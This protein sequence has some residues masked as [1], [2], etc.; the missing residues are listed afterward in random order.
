MKYQ[1]ASKHDQAHQDNPNTG[2]ESHA[3]SKPHA[4]TS[5]GV[6]LFMA[7][8]SSNTL[9]GRDHVQTKLTIGSPDDEYEQEADRV[10]DEVM[11]KP[12]S[13][14]QRQTEEGTKCKS[15]QAQ[16]EVKRKTIWRSI[17]PIVQRQRIQKQSWPSFDLSSGQE[18]E[19]VVTQRACINKSIQLSADIQRQSESSFEEVT[20][21]EDEYVR[22]KANVGTAE[23]ASSSVEKSL[24]KSRGQGIPLANHTLSFMEDRFGANFGNVRIHNDGNAVNL[25]RHLKSHAF[26]HGSDIYFNSGKYNPESLQGQ[27]LLAHELT[28]VVQQSPTH[29]LQKQNENVIQCQ[30]DLDKAPSGLSCTLKTGTGHTPGT[31]IMFAEGKSSIS[32][33]DKAQLATFATTWIANGSSATVFVDG[34]AS[35]DGAQS[36]NWRLSCKRAEAVKT[37]LANNGVSSSKIILLAH[38]ESTEFSTSVL[39]DNRRVVVSSLSIPTPPAIPPAVPPQPAPLPLKS[40]KFTSDHG[41]LKDNNTNWLYSGSVVEPEWVSDPLRNKSISQTKNTRLVADVTVN[42]APAGTSFDLIGTGINSNDTSFSQSGNISTGTDQVISVTAD[43]NLPNAVS[44]LDRYIIWKIKVGGREQLAG[45][46]GPHKIYITYATPI[47]DVTEKRMA[48]SC[49]KANTQDAPEKIADKIQLGVSSDTSFGGMIDGWN[50]LAGGAGDCDNQAR[51]MSYAVNL[52]GVSPATVRYVRASTNAGAGNC[53]DL[54][55]R[56]IWAWGTIYLIMDFNVGS[57]HYWNAYEGICDTAGKYYAITPRIKATDDYDMLTKISCLQ[58]WVKSPVP[59]GHSGWGV[60]AAFSSVPK[61]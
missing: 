18:E 49:Q 26:T 5:L 34:Y 19:A 11:R 56:W 13:R 39:E 59:P 53:L 10:A 9:H 7:R 31:D 61:P 54:E 58:Y 24:Y 6:P 46:S 36:T 25:N 12:D 15:C 41:L 51:L 29:A 3:Q 17:T 47:G 37:E 35:T 55:T 52:L 23:M 22:T 57:G 14:I 44:Q 38:G 45:F 33:A 43:A 30:A 16:E 4:A 21:S 48:W 27:H 50:L 32:P 40:I 42:I 28:H 1:N 20:E 60:T 8:Q 2:Q